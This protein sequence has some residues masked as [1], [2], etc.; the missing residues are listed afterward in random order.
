MTKNLFNEE[1]RS[2]DS[3][4]LLKKFFKTED[5]VFRGVEMVL[6]AVSVAAVKVS[7]ESILESYVSRYENHIDSR[8]NLGEKGSNE[9]FQVAQNGPS[10][11]MCDNIVKEAMD[12]YW[13]GNNWHF[14]KSDRTNIH[15]FGS[16]VLDKIK[17]TQSNLGFM[18]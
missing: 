12:R 9:E 6:H 11:A 7:C 5:A 18:K 1:I 17:N 10:I 3:K 16:K 15:S 13:K 14:F 8:R 2:Y 4:E